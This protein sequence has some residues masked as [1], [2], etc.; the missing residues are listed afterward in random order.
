MS[1]CSRPDG[2]VD[3]ARDAEIEDLP[4]RP[5]AR[6]RFSGLMSRWTMPRACARRASACATSRRIRD[7][8]RTGSGPP[9]ARGGR[10]AIPPPVEGHRARLEDP[11][12]C[13]S[14]ARGRCADAAARAANWISRRKRSWLTAAASS[15]ERTFTTTR[16]SK[17]VPRAP[18]TAGSS[19]RPGVRVPGGTHRPSRSAG[20]S[21]ERHHSTSGGLGKGRT[22]LRIGRERRESR[23]R[24]P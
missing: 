23:T 22:N 14:R 24:M 6:K 20:G 10:A 17:R 19:H 2:L 1:E 12:R 18:G 9:R 15:G 16:R 5:C 3:R 4:R 7:A 13:R 21:L 8:S 11:R